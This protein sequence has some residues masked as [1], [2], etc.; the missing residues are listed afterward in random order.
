MHVMGVQGT[1]KSTFLFNLIRQDIENGEGLAVLDPHGDLVEQILGI[2]PPERIQDVVLV[3]PSDEE[4][5]VG[6]NILSAHSDAEKRLLASDLVSVFERLS[7]SWGDQMGSVLQNA[8]LAF[9]ES[10]RG[11]TLTDLRRFLLEPPFRAKFLD[12]VRDP[13]IVYYWR[14]GFSQLAGNKSIGSV[15][16]R[17]NDFLAP[18][19]IRYMVS[20]KENRLDF[21]DI[22]DSGK[23]FLAKLPKGEIGKENSFL[24]GSLLV[25]KFQQMIMA[26]QA[27]RAAAR[28]DFFLYIDEFHNFITPSMAEILT[29]VRKYRLGM[30]LAHQELRQLERDREVASA[31]L[32]MPYAR[33]LFRVGDADARAMENGLSFFEARDLQNLSKGEA[34]CRIEKADNDFNLTVPFPE[35]VDQEGA[36]AIRLAVIAASRQSYAAP[37]VDIEAAERAESESTVEEAEPVKAKRTRPVPP[38]VVEKK[39]EEIQKPPVQEKVDSS[40]TAEP[41]LKPEQ[42]RLAARDLG[43]GGAQHQ[44]IQ[45]RIKAAADE[46]DFQSLIEKPVLDGQG[47]VDLWLARGALSIA[48]EISISTTIDHEVGNVAKCLKAGIQLV[49]VIC[50]DDTRL[51]KIAAGVTGSLGAEMAARVRYF[52]PDQFIAHLQTLPI[53]PTEKKPTMRRGY[54]IKTVIS[55]LSPEKQKEKD[56]AAIRAIADSMRKK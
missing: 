17:L 50:L 20:Q 38:P 33:V 36:E 7:K 46:L 31:V 30:I 19:P 41:F 23:I 44:A 3:D 10:D 35:P 14:T 45:K 48:C 25:A 27:Q 6:F 12:S 1:G 51:R 13:N 54:R 28:K 39:A 55:E 49:I 15:I 16:T 42:P 40:V 22:V 43:R 56:A 47:S 4:Y 24:L 32:S 9:L 8:I 53:E 21:A 52:Q 2:I 18:K 34:I 37:R 26:R 29:D 11:G 5:S